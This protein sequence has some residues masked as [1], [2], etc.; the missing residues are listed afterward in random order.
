MQRYVDLSIIIPCFNCEKT[1]L[2]CLNSIKIDN[3]INYEI[4]LID[5]GSTDKTLEVINK[6]IDDKI[7]VFHNQNHGVSYTRNFGIDKSNGEYLVFIDSDDSVEKDYIK[8]LYDGIKHSDF[9]ICN[10]SYVEDNHRY[11]NETKNLKENLNIDEFKKQFMYYFEYELINPPWNKI[12]KKE[13]IVKNGIKFNEKINLGEDLLFNL[14]YL[15]KIKTIN[16]VNIPLYNYYV[17]KYTLSTKFRKDYLD[18]EWILIEKIKDFLFNTEDGIIDEKIQKY[19]GL[20]IISYIQSFF[21]DSC[22]I[23]NGEKMIAI[24]KLLMNQDYKKIMENFKSDNYEHMIIKNAFAKE[25]EKII[26]YL[27]FFKKYIKKVLHK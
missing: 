8:Y 22:K 26:F 3:G 7:K 23:L 13:I 20:L 17:G 25:N 6:L 4:L 15:K 11:V 5:D 19:E 14:E 16:Y 2:N 1:I 10:F 9:S 18:I 24:K 21:S 27:Q 12:F